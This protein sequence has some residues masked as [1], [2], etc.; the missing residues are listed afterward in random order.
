MWVLLFELVDRDGVWYGLNQATRWT[1]SNNIEGHKPQFELV[2][3]ENGVELFDQLGCKLLL[4]QV[5]RAFHNDR[6]QSI[7][8]HLAV[9]ALLLCL[10]AHLVK[11]LITE[12][13]RWLFNLLL[14]TFVQV[15]FVGIATWRARHASDILAIV[16]GVAHVGGVSVFQVF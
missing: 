16:G 5:V 9:L 12:Q 11:G 13:A 15:L 14:F 1:R 3:L 8:Q 6:D 4:S 10:S 7:V 2:R